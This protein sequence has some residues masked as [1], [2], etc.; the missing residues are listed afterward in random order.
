MFITV[1]ESNV[2][3]SW[4]KKPRLDIFEK[5]NLPNVRDQMVNKLNT[6][7]YGLFA[8]KKTFSKERVQTIKH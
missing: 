3:F 2:K 6:L 7:T 8:L 1:Y 5:D 4:F